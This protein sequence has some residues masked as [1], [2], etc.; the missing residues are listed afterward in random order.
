MCIRDRADTLAPAGIDMSD[1]T[2][3]QNGYDLLGGLIA[4]L[5]Q[6]M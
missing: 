6:L 3:W 5:K 4:E 2:F 1:P